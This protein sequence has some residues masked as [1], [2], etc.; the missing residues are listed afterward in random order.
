MVTAFPLLKC[1][2]T[3]Y[4]RHCEP[5]PG[6]NAPDYRILHIQSQNFSGGH[7][8]VLHRSARCLDTDIN[9]CLVRQ[10]F[11]SFCFTKTTTARHATSATSQRV[12]CTRLKMH[13]PTVPFFLDYCV[14][15]Q[16]TFV[17][18][19]HVNRFCYLLTYL[20][21]WARV[22]DI[23]QSVRNSRYT[24]FY[25]KWAI[26]SIG[27][28]WVYTPADR[29]TQWHQNKLESGDTRPVQS[30][31]KNLVSYPSTFWRHKYN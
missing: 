1:L 10:R 2:R 23:G 27:I 17:I 12:F 28:I 18:I 6:Q 19:R 14:V 5:F 7:I 24:G 26:R 20:L 9:F 15:C 3:Y 22:D 31:G 25:A 13:L 30:A 4:W 16:V 21:S 11:H 29:P 8:P